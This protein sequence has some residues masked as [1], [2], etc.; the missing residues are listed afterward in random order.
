MRPVQVTLLLLVGILSYACQADE[1]TTEPIA[2]PLDI[3]L[4]ESLQ[5]AA[6]AVGGS[7]KSHFQLPASNA[8]ANIPQDPLNPLNTDKV[9]LGQLLY[10][11]TALGVKSELAIGA[12]TY[13]CAS[14]HF[15]AAGFQAGKA[16]G[17]G[18]GGLG[19]GLHGE[20]RGKSPDYPASKIDVQPIR[21]PSAMNT[22]YQELMLW[23]GQF[24]AT[25]L[26]IGT[27]AQWLPETPLATNELGYQGLEIQAIAGLGVHR[28]DCTEEMMTSMDYARLFDA[29][30]PDVPTSKRYN[31][32]QAGLAIAAF[33]R[34]ILANK[35]PFQQWLQGNMTAMNKRE[36]RGA[37]L[38]FGD[39][40]CI[41]CHNNAA[42][43]TM[44]FHAL[45]MG[46]LVDASQRVF[47]VTAS[48]PARLGRGGFTKKAED[49]YKFKVPQ[50]YNLKDSP[51]YGHGA[52]FGSIEEVVRYKNTAQAQN[53]EVPSS[54]LATDF[55]AL[56]LS[57]QDIADLVTFIEDALYDPNLQRYQPASV[58]SGACI[59]NNDF[60]TKEHLG[61]D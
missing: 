53:D 48:N 20:G 56:N 44:D 1:L 12:S 50:L 25:G 47:N 18:D 16:Q 13:S 54:Q 30:F 4:D 58:H 26:N 24:G 34:T 23:N 3:A 33:E 22:A 21:T 28:M 46:D 27:E 11:E 57:E 55:Q 2:D 5:N 52:T 35:A 42:L 45:G 60:I 29:A 51:F 32:E 9:N 37:L 40:G 61:C 6:L 43:S 14:C 31:L 41:N 7:D 15:A 59:P 36:K 49:N 10:H 39:A 8:F 19:I 17:I 38:F